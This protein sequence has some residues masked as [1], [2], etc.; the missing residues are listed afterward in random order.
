M[1]GHVEGRQKRPAEEQQARREEKRRKEDENRRVDALPR[2]G[3]VQSQLPDGIYIPYRMFNTVPQ[4]AVTGK[5]L[6]LPSSDLSFAK[7]K[8][9]SLD[10]EYRM[11]FLF[12][13]DHGLNVDLFDPEI[14]ADADLD[15]RSVAKS[16]FTNPAQPAPKQLAGGFLRKGNYIQNDVFSQGHNFLLGHEAAEKKMI[17]VPEKQLTAEEAVRL[18]ENTFSDARLHPSHPKDPLKTVKKMS[19]IL[20]CAQHMGREFVQMMF[21]QPPSNADH[22]V[23][24]VL[25]PHK[26]QDLQTAEKPT[27]F[28]YAAEDKPLSEAHLILKDGGNVKLKQAQAY[29]WEN[30]L[31]DQ[32]LRTNTENASATDLVWATSRPDLTM[33]DAP[34]LY[35]PLRGVPHRN[36]KQLSAGVAPIAYNREALLAAR[37]PNESERQKEEATSKRMTGISASDDRNFE[38]AQLAEAQ[39]MVA[40]LE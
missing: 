36:I 1:N 16:T 34:V 35:L 31:E 25:L 39:R 7:D 29:V 15:T 5:L 30:K 28:A 19:Q 33:D 8:S 10:L 11:P 40:E 3:L 32:A 24:V 26:D 21:D 12:A 23:P 20:P 6:A 38:L 13:H 2:L 9:T 37:A 17:R 4:A 27:Y 14:Y 22:P 18:I